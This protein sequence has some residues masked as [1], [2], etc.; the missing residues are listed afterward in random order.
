MDSII[1]LIWQK[2]ELRETEFLSKFMQ[3]ASG[4][5]RIFGGTGWAAIVLG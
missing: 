3:L 4:R 2:R 5:A 1:T